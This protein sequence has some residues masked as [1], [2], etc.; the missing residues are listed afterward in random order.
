ME[1]KLLIYPDGTKGGEEG[2]T[3]TRVRVTTDLPARKNYYIG[4]DPGS[5]NMGIAVMTPAK[6]WMIGYLYQIGLRDVADAIDRIQMIRAVTKS[7]LRPFTLKER[8]LVACVEQAAYAALYGQTTLSESRTA[9]IVALIDSEVS[10]IYV[11]T[12]AHVRK[13]VFES[14]KVRSQ[15]VWPDLPPDAGSALGCAY[16]A[17]VSDAGASTGLTST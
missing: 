10:K 5:R 7:I 13:V 15:E 14:G 12:P 16:Y 17:Y 1:S 9:A 6:G 11:E 4:I 3:L 2:S 8:V